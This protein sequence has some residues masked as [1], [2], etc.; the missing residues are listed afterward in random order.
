[1]K[2]DLIAN[3]I[4]QLKRWKEN[5]EIIE[6][7]KKEIKSLE[8]ICDDLNNKYLNIKNHLLKSMSLKEFETREAEAKKVLNL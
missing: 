3:S 4:Q 7:Q 2:T 8:R 1:M 5:E 6:N